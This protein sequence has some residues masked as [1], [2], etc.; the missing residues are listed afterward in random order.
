M[1]TRF[2]T[3]DREP[4]RITITWEVL[5]FRHPRCCCGGANTSHLL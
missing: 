2:A 5:T 3:R 1:T 4:E